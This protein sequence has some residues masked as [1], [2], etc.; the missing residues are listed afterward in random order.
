MKFAFL[1]ELIEHHMINQT[2][3]T[4]PESQK[5]LFIGIT[6]VVVQKLRRDYS[7]VT[8]LYKACYDPAIHAHLTVKMTLRNLASFG[9]LPSNLFCYNVKGWSTLLIWFEL[10]K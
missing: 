2:R 7:L 8:G 1:W 6:E 4:S 3:T 10:S 9:V 5:K